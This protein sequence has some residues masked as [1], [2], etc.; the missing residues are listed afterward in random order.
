MS[1][2]SYLCY[3]GIFFFTAIEGNA[4]ELKKNDQEK[5]P[6]SPIPNHTKATL[7]AKKEPDK[8]LKL[9]GK[10]NVV[11]NI[12]IDINKLVDAMQKQY[13]NIKTATFRFEQSYKHPFLTAMENS[14]GSVAYKKTGGKMVWTYL[15]PK[16][17][18]K[19]FFIVGKKFTYYSSSD[20]TAYTHN[21]YDQDALSFSIAFLLGSGNLNSSF[22]IS[23]FEG[24]IPNKTLS[25][26]TLAPKET[27]SPVKKIHIG[28]DKDTK[29]ME[30]I[31]EDPS[32]GKNH[33]K[34]LD[35]KINQI[36]L[37]KV[38][39]FTA[40]KGVLVQ[41]MPNVSCTAQEKKVLKSPSLSPVQA[42][43]KNTPAKKP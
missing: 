25:W 3:L 20:K 16:D 27:N 24:E 6:N 31:V 17:K 2:L 26:L 18:Q 41:P 7:P 22:N 38:F 15:E 9:T 33:F 8:L 28:V 29:V 14:K 10:T 40:P 30:S 42:G 34:F 13:D 1:L 12:G 39:L 4:I 43:P 5:A 37:D 35:M 32:G 21:C 23:R 11:K 36:V 19:Q